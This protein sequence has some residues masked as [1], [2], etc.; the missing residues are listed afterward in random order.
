MDGNIV[1]AEFAMGASFTS[2]E[3]RIQGEQDP[4]D[5][6]MP[7]APRVIVMCVTVTAQVLV[8]RLYSLISSQ[9]MR[10]HMNWKSLGNSTME[11]QLHLPE[12]STWVCDTRQNM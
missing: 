2:V 3:C 5:C 4:V 9:T 1:R 12:S 11:A 7:I 8:E 10:V 6:E